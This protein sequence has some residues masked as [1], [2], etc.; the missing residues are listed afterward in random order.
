M[1]DYKRISWGNLDQI[2]RMLETAQEELAIMWD[3]GASRMTPDECKRLSGYLVSIR[4]SQSRM[5]DTLK[6]FEALLPA[7]LEGNKKRNEK[8]DIQKETT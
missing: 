8:R 2:T 3:L 4:L 1:D 5:R 7:I 6:L